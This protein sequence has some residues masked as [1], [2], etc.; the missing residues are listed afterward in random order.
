MQ[1]QQRNSGWWIIGYDH[2]VITP[3]EHDEFSDVA[4][5]TDI[6]PY[7]TKAEAEADMRGITKFLKTEGR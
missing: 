5:D 7:R 4:A 3:P 6:G 1:L 2:C